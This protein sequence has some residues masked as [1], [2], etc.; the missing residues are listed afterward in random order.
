MF[1]NATDV[2]NLIGTFGVDD[3]QQ[4][5]EDIMDAKMVYLYCMGTCLVI[6][7]LYNVILKFFAKIL[8]WITILITGASLIAGS[9]YLTLY[10]KE[11]YIDTP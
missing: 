5:Y 1:L 10:H 4:Y 11:N 8:V 6:T 2:D 3:I 9:Y 7:I